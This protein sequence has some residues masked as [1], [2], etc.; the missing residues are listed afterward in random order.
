MCR[1]STPPS[2]NGLLGR[3]TAV[4]GYATAVTY[5]PSGQV[6]QIN[7]SNGTISSY[8]QNTR[9]WPSN[10]ITKLGTTNYLSSSYTYDGAGRLTGVQFTGA[11]SIALYV[12]RYCKQVV[13]IEEVPEAIHDAEENLY[14]ASDYFDWLYRFAEHLVEAGH[15]YVDSQDA[16]AIRA[17]GLAIEHQF[18]ELFPDG[19]NELPLLQIPMQEDGRADCPP[20]EEQ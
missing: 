3:P 20:F 8:A 2:R 1:E 10:F 16:D 11:G 5:W 6:K 15:A 4:S 17:A 19:E 13:G 9:L 14:F 7:Y 18:D 12:A